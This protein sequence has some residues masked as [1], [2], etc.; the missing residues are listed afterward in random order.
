MQ[1]F[2]VVI[3]GGGVV[4]CAIA[5][6][7][8]RYK[9]KVAVLEKE[10]ELGTGTT[11]ANTGLIHSGFNVDKNTIKGRLNLEA[12]PLFDRLVSQLNIPFQRNGSL[13]VAHNR[14]DYQA[15][16]HSIEEAK[17]NGVKGIKWL[18]KDEL[19]EKEPAINKDSF[20]AVFAPSGGIICPFEFT[21]ALGQNAH[22]NGVVFF[23]GTEVKK[24]ITKE[25][26][27]E[28]LETSRGFIRVS[29][30][31][32]AAGL[33]ADTF[34]EEIKN[35]GITLK[36]R[37]GQYLVYDREYPV[38]VKHTLFPRPTEV[39]KGII[40]TPTIHGNL[41]VGPNAEQVEGRDALE[42][43]ETGIKEVLEGARKLVPNID[44][45]AVIRMFS[46]LRAVANN[47]FII[48]PAKK[49][50]GLVLAVGIQSPGLTAAPRIGELVAEILKDIGL[51][52]K[53]KPDFQEERTP[54]KS[55]GKMNWGE[56]A[57]L[58]EKDLDYGQV[59][60]RCEGITRGEIRDAIL[61]PL[62]AVT[63]DGIKRRT[64]AASGRCQSG[65]CGPR[66]I[67]LLKEF[68]GISPFE[69]SLRGGETQ[70]L[71]YRSK[72]LLL[73]GGENIADQ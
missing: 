26:W 54:L 44:T 56:R 27:V 49:T 61:S 63:I 4:G 46:G 25:G 39:S 30:V 9:I 47:D 17:A 24:I 22:S 73:K 33:L 29:F 2:D 42:T 1:K 32:N 18:N 53:G 3:I 65:F 50:R 52:L 13:V 11:K 60:C 34:G 48:A 40:V 14:E 64:R 51:G 7:L 58:V 12:N 15:L 72:E 67:E 28:G 31:V 36:A 43:T 57:A 62:G 38:K 68:A 21:L 66:L 41:M 23:L 16:L 70:I 6:E 55:P 5:R 35:E 45:S 59:I 8:S 19:K 71:K 10:T 37:R 20:G 69:A